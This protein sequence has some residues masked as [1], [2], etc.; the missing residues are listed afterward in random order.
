MKAGTF[1]ALKVEVEIPY[2][3]RRSKG[4]SVSKRVVETFWYAPE[5]GRWV[6]KHYN[7]SGNPGLEVSELKSFKRGE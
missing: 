3:E 6:K 2:E 5:V 1:N 7:E 4:N